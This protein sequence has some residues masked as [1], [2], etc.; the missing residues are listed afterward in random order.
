MWNQYKNK[1]S[2]TPLKRVDYIFIDIHNTLC[3]DLLFWVIKT[4]LDEVIL[5]DAPESIDD[6]WVVREAHGVAIE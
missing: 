3:A 1:Y 5:S 6:I 4:V 2:P